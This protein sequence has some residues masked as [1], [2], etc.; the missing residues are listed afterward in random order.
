[1]HSLSIA[2][3]YFAAKQKAGKE[4]NETSP[5]KAYLVKLI[6]LFL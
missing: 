2:A 3:A 6:K 1:V 5:A 4:F